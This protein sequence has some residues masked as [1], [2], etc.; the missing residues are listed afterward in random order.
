MPST[1]PFHLERRT[2]L[3]TAGVGLAAGA[4]AGCHT[5]ESI[6]PLL[7]P[8]SRRQGE[9]AQWFATTCREC[10]AGCGM[11]V[12]VN[13]G[14]P[15][16][17]E[18]NPDHPVNRGKL[19]MRGQAALEGI[20]NP[21]RFRGPQ[22][23]D[24]YGRL[25]P[26]SW[27]DALEFWLQQL[28]PATAMPGEVVWLGQL[29]TGTLA[30]L[31]ADWMQQQDFTA[32]LIY[33]PF[34]YDGLRAAQ[35][36]LGGRAVVPTFH[37]DRA[38]YL[39]SF[40]AEFLE[41]WVSN[42]E[43]ARQFAAMHSFDANP[44]GAPFV[45]IG[46]RLSLTAANAD[47]YWPARPGSEAALAWALVDMLAGAGARPPAVERPAPQPLEQVA[48]LAGLPTDYLHRAADHLRTVRPSLVLGPGY[49]NDSPTAASCH[50]AVAVL[51]RMLATR[52][53]PSIRLRRMP[54][55]G[56]HGATR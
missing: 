27:R 24:R 3:K 11:V 10:P 51:N 34:S 21:D 56:S 25:Q 35:A 31:T 5:P 7:T 37:I 50:L 29:E 54:L 38:R 23:R 53:S 12:R 49:G 30:A 46:P 19:C 33:E 9:R 16:K 32:P 17:A 6:L 8:D 44:A 13:A 55:A 48:A 18:G 28:R 39:L 15:T 4:L 52:G 43:F 2:F 22:R 42:V 40:G 36:A 1:R 26:D 41:T 45:A 14:R 20:Y 47:E